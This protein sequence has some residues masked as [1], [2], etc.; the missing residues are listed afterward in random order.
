LGHI[1]YNKG[2]I[3]STDY[4]EVVKRVRKN[5][6]GTDAIILDFF[7]ASVEL[8]EKWI[9]TRDYGDFICKYKDLHYSKVGNKLSNIIEDYL[10]NGNK[11]SLEYLKN[12]I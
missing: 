10:I 8:T 5:L 4:Y 1:I 2:Y 11:G 12:C 9:K 6:I 3:C 7:E